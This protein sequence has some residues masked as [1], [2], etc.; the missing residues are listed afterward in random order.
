MTSRPTND[1][2]VVISA[3]AVRRV[4]LWLVALALLAAAVYFGRSI[5]NRAPAAAD[6]IDHGAYQA[7]FLTTGQAFY[8]KLTIADADTYLLSDVFYIVP[9]DTAQRLVKRGTEVFGPREPMV[10][11]ARQVLFFENI[12][13]DS[14]VGLGIRA[15]KLGGSTPA[16]P[17]TTALPLPTATAT[18]RP[19]ASR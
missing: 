14:D 13:D 9:N 15:I 10:I 17:A 12:R 6:Q 11:L 3:A 18:A 16:A 8:G 7:V 5:F 1:A 2:A 4:L 19:S